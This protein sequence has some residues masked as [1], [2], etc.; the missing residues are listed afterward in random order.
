VSVWL[1]SDTRSVVKHCAPPPSA[2]WEF[3][4]GCDPSRSTY[5]TVPVYGEGTQLRYEAGVVF[6]VTLASLPFL[7]LGRRTTT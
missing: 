2:I 7:G 3:F 6:L 1:D 4:G 5:T